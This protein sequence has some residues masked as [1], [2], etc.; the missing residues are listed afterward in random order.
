MDNLNESYEKNVNKIFSYNLKRCMEFYCIQNVDL[1]K[2]LDVSVQTVSAWTN[3]HK[4]PRMKMLDK[5]CTV[6]HCNR[7]ELLDEGGYVNMEGRKASEYYEE[8]SNAYLEYLKTLPK[9]HHEI[10]SLRWEAA[11]AGVIQSVD[12]LDLDE[13]EALAEYASFLIW[14]HEKKKG[15]LL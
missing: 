3:G 1:A 6:L 10:L 8:Q 13:L 14:K 12:Y 5:I 4:I 11:K 7:S 9:D 2:R 15:E